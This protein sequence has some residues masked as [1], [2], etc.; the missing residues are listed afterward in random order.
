MGAVV[1]DTD[2][3]IYLM[4]WEYG[5]APGDRTRCRSVPPHSGVASLE[6]QGSDGGFGS[7]SM[8]SGTGR[9]C[10]PL[11]PTDNLTSHRSGQSS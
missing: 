5:N 2:R 4:E 9:A 10:K 3:T 6:Q 8:D 7:V 1:N 11:D